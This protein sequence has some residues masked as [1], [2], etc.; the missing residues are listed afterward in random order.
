MKYSLETRWRIAIGIFGVLFLFLGPQYFELF[1]I[2]GGWI[3]TLRRRPY[4]APA[5]SNFPWRSK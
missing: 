2:I 4:F 5:S 3:W 1:T